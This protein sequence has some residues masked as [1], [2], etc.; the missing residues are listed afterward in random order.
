MD[1]PKRDNRHEWLI[2]VANKLGFENMPNDI[3]PKAN[4]L[5][6]IGYESSYAVDFLKRWLNISNDL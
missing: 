1:K 6:D 4:D 3:L 2:K 5:Y